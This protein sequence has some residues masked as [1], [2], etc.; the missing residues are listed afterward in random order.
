MGLTQNTYTVAAQSCVDW[1]QRG[2]ATAL[3][4][5]SRMLGQTIGTA[6]YGGAVNLTL[7]GLLGG[8]AVSRIL[9]PGLRDQLSAAQLGPV[10]LAVGDAIR[11]VYLIAGF[12]VVLSLAAGLSLPKGLSPTRRGSD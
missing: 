4:A 11:N 1:S 9:D 6:I 10:M 7:S 12:F 3:V 2:T 5:F 8:D